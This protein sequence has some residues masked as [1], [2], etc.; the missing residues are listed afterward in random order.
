[1]KLNPSVAES[2]QTYLST[3]EGQHSQP[4]DTEDAA[5]DIVFFLLLE[6]ARRQAR[7]KDFDPDT[8]CQ[9]LIE[10]AESRVEG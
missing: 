2:G 10:A 6:T 5:L 4:A 1:M 8:A 9:A 7:R 3:I